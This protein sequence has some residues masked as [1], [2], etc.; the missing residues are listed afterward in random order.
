LANGWL[1]KDPFAN[2][3]SKIKEVERNFLTQ[4]EINNIYAKEFRIDRLDQVRDIFLFSC[5]TGLAYIDVKNLTKPPI[6]L[7][8]D[9]EKWIFTHRQKTE[10]ASKIPILPITQ[11]IIDKYENHPES[12]NQN[13]LPPIVSKQITSA[14]LKKVEIYNSKRPHYSKFI[15]TPNQMHMQNQIKRS[16]YTIKNSSKILF[17]TV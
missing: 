8:I 14:Y 17:T 10:T 4:D 6:G 3:K 11:M 12:C 16:T 15:L 5:F 2:Y 7:G 9:G 1:D 13:K